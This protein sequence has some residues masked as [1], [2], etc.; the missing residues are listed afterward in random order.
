M[1][2]FYFQPPSIYGRITDR[3]PYNALMIRANTMKCQGF[4]THATHCA[5]DIEQTLVLGAHGP[6]RVHVVLVKNA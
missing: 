6:Y 1:R 3:P 2:K 5:H 4:F